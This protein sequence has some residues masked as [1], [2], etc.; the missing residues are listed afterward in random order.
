MHTT[1]AAMYSVSFGVYNVTFIK[2]D[3]YH[4]TDFYKK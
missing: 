4:Y 2:Y 3:P 1:V